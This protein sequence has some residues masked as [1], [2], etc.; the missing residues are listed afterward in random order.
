[1]TSNPVEN[2]VDPDHKIDLDRI[3]NKVQNH[4]MGALL[5]QNAMAA[6]VIEDQSEMIRGLQ[7]ELVEKSASA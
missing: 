4:P 7:K 2:T 6:C 3:L 1:M 5:V